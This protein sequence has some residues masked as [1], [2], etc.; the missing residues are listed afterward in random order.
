MSRSARPWQRRWSGRSIASATVLGLVSA[1]LVF[2]AIRSDGY[3]ATKVNLDDASVWV[4]NTD[5]GY[6][7][8]LNS[9]NRALDAAVKTDGLE[10]AEMWQLGPQVT[11]GFPP[12]TAKLDP[13]MVRMEPVNDKTGGKLRDSRAGV[14]VIVDQTAGLAWVGQDLDLASSTADPEQALKLQL[15]SRTVAAVSADGDALIVDPINALYWVVRLDDHQAPHPS[16]RQSLDLG[17]D[18][19][20][21]A[22]LTAVGEV[23]V[24]MYSSDSGTYLAWPGRDEPVAVGDVDVMLQQ[25]G[26]RADEVLVAGTSGLWSVSLK[27]AAVTQVAQASGHPAAPVRLGGCIHAAWAGSQTYLQQCGGAAPKSWTIG[28]VGTS[29]DLTFRV[30]GRIIALNGQNGDVF[31]V[32]ADEPP[33]EVDNWDEVMPEESPVDPP[34]T[35]DPEPAECDTKTPAEP[36]PVPDTYGVHQGETVRM[37]VLDND[38]D[39]NCDALSVEMPDSWDA[40]RSGTL[41]IIDHGQTFQYQAPLDAPTG[42]I[43][44]PYTINDGNGAKAEAELTIV[45]TPASQHGSPPEAVRPSRTVVEQGKSVEYNVLVDMIDAD[46]DAMSVVGAD[47]AGQGT[48]EFN[49]NGTI[50]YSAVGTSP[51]AKTI[52]VMV[53]DIAGTTVEQPL[54]VEVR[55]AGTPLPPIARNDYVEGK[56]GTEVVLH[57]LENDS[58]ANDDQLVLA[59]VTIAEGDKGVLSVSQGDD[60]ELRLRATAR[61]DYRVTYTASDGGPEGGF[62]V[63]RFRALETIENTPPV[64]VSDNVNVQRGRSVNINVLGNDFDADGDLMVVTDA[65]IDD[66]TIPEAEVVVVNGQFVRVTAGSVPEPTRPIPITYSVSDGVNQPVTA[67]LLVQVLVPADNLPPDVQGDRA[68][69]RAG[70]VVTVDV[71]ANDTDPDADPLTVTLAK[72]ETSTIGGNVWIS[73]NKVRFLAGEEAGRVYLSYTADDSPL[74]DGQRAMSAQVQIDVVAADK[75][76]TAPQA[77]PLEARV[78]SGG[79]ATVEVPVDGVDPDGDSVR[80]LGFGPISDQGSTATLGAVTIEDGNFVYQAWP[81][82]AGPDSFTYQLIDSKGA[83]SAPAVVRVTVVSSANHAPVAVRDEVTVRPNRTLQLAVLANDTDPDGDELTV[84][85]AVAQ[86][87]SEALEPTVAEG[88]QLILMVPG[89]GTYVARYTVG[90]GRGGLSYAAIIVHADPDAPLLPPNLRDDIAVPEGSNPGTATVNPFDNDDDPDSARTPDS[91]GNRSDIVLKSLYPADAGSVAGDT[92]TFTQTDEDRLVLYTVVDFDGNEASAL[93]LVPKAGDRLPRLRDPL[94]E[95]TVAMGQ[96][97]E[98]RLAD[99]VDPGD[100]V[101]AGSELKGIRGTTEY[102]PGDMTR[103]V[104]TATEVSPELFQPTGRV[105]FEVTDDPSN[106]SRTVR[107]EVPITITYDGPLPIHTSPAVVKVERL[108]APVT[109]DLVSEG[110]VIDRNTSGERAFSGLKAVGAPVAD[111]QL[112]PAGLLTVTPHSDAV[113]G[114][115]TEY[116]YTVQHGSMSATGAV[117]VVVVRSTRPKPTAPNFTFRLKNSETVTHDVS[118]G[119][120]NSFAAEGQPLRL[121]QVVGP[122]QGEQWGSLDY[123]LDGTSTVITY[124]PDPAFAGTI[125]VRYVLADAADEPAAEGQASQSSDPRRATGTI[126]Y[127]VIGP[128]LQPSPPT[129]LEVRSHTVVLNIGWSDPDFWQGTRTDADFVVKWPGGQ[130]HTGGQTLVTI[131]GL[132]NDVPVQFTVTAHNEAGDG[133]E[134]LPSLQVRPDQVPD[135]P[136]PPRITDEGDG[137]LTVEWDPVVPD[138]S[139]V[140]GYQLLVNDP[141]VV[142]SELSASPPYSYVVTGLKNGQNYAFAIIARNRAETNGGKSETSAWSQPGHPYTV[143][144]APRNVVVQDVPG[145]NGASVTVTWAAPTFDGGDPI[146]NYRISVDGGGPTIETGSGQTTS[147]PMDPPSGNRTFSVWAHNKRGWSLAAGTL[148]YKVI[149]PPSAPTITAVN[150][151]GSGQLQIVYTGTANWENDTGTGTYEYSVGGA[152]SALPG[153]G[154]ISGLVNCRTYSVTIRAYNG[155]YYTNSNTMSGAPYGAPNTPSAWSSTSGQ[156][157]TWNWSATANGDCG[158]SVVASVNTDG[159]ISNSLNGPVTRTYGYNQTRTLTVTVS[160][161]RSTSSPATSQATTGGQPISVL[162]SQGAMYTGGSANEG[163]CS[164]YNCKW[165]HINTSGWSPGQSLTLRCNANVG[166]L[167][168]YYVN[169]DGSGSWN[170]DTYMMYGNVSN[171][172][173]TVNGVQSNTVTTWKNW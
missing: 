103:F 98:I 17:F 161:G 65:V 92:I 34:T 21:G 149:Q 2:A 40:E 172:S 49:A 122:D 140:E 24:L 60:G 159:V 18:V 114:A 58:D 166:S 15:S 171:V 136:N 91:A 5:T 139:P 11:L 156:D 121:I 13:V 165:V 162:V 170:F 80:L 51:D 164:A 142:I 128:P 86:Q 59:Q 97:L 143:P 155:R 43:T 104:Y 56:V 31:L 41:S 84:T 47:A 45:V 108:G 53:A 153:N 63:I 36:E 94:P 144:D 33:T 50:K 81:D 132:P 54:I 167:G 68:V 107:L 126:T 1:V 89:E 160:D 138:G 75:D 120:V 109:L 69:V 106:P 76:N 115:L 39:P 14:S 111:V 20:E 141:G 112:S 38:R 105:S 25:P 27:T 154:I 168:P 124:T 127:N 83:R 110:F 85:E 152:W 64:A 150:E 29:D 145:T 82:S 42:S 123:S 79:R 119:A 16:G 28:E 134:S 113:L 62:G 99:I 95:L 163:S 96:S 129:V 148:L 102:L 135:R 8:R 169:A 52:T 131:E 93:I 130:Q 100:A 133:P 9:Q 57:P 67:Q 46:G 73:G 71:L 87:G 70:D 23:P 7:G 74:L 158:A 35:A 88:R 147:Q 66:P 101:L 173:C 30:N 151:A 116:T 3:H 32:N 90:D 118:E 77:K 72:I 125:V 157:I 6:V 22:R 26:P 48:V 137:S 55:P 146:D 12:G 37:P 10:A 19:P 44:V 61:G 78:Y 117:R 4:F